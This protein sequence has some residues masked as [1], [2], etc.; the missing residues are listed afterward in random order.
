MKTNCITEIQTALLSNSELKEAI[1]KDKDGNDRIYPS[2]Q[3]PIAKEYPRITMF[4]VNNSD[5]DDYADDTCLS[6]EA[7][8]QINVW[9][10]SSSL[11]AQIAGLVDDTM[12]ALEWSRGSAP[13]FYEPDIEVYHKAMRYRNKFFDI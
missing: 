10:K 12:K 4:E 8:V 7:I 5:S 13:D 3:A 2:E 6:S 9:A 1:G 11:R